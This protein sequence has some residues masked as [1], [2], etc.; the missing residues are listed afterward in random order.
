MTY[1]Q[2]P[3]WTP[4]EDAMITSSTLTDGELSRLL[5]RSEVAIRVR[6]QKVKDRLTTTKPRGWIPTLAEIEE[7]K[8]MVRE[9][10]AEK[11]ANYFVT[12][13]SGRVG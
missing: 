10:R 11:N 5:G 9:M 3:P 12:N 1:R 6:R 7:R 2:A 8:A 4:Q 13:E